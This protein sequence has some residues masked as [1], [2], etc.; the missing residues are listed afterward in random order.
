MRKALR[1]PLLHFVAL[2]LLLF[3]WFEWRGGRSGSRHVVVTP[4]QIQH[5]AAGFART[6]QR[7]PGDTELK[8]LVDEYV[9][10]E[11]AA[12]EAVAEGLDR[13][14]PIVRKRLRQRLEFL[15]EDAA[16]AGAPTDAELQAWL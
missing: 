3:L 16:E 13:D 4:G 8:A 6:W 7:P 10:E 11:L 1:E 5:L 12:R 15:A 9:K 2:G 14:D